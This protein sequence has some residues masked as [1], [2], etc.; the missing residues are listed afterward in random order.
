MFL[1]EDAID[2]RLLKPGLPQEP[3]TFFIWGNS[4]GYPML[5]VITTDVRDGR[6]VYWYGS[7]GTDRKAEILEMIRIPYYWLI[8]HSEF[9]SRSIEHFNDLN[10]R[11]KEEQ[12]NVQG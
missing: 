4:A 6:P 5:A 8:G 12:A 11:I 2:R 9:S 10:A 7:G 1:L 3:G